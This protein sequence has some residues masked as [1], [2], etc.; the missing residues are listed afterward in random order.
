MRGSAD[1]LMM[2]NREQTDQLFALMNRGANV[3]TP[4]AVQIRGDYFGKLTDQFGVQWMVTAL[5]ELDVI[6]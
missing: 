6:E 2:D 1:I 3:T 4:L 5:N